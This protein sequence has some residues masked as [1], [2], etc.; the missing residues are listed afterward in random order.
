[1]LVAFAFEGTSAPDG[2]MDAIGRAVLASLEHNGGPAFSVPALAILAALGV[3]LVRWVRR[4][5]TAERAEQEKRDALHSVALSEVREGRNRRE[6]VRVPA[7]VPMTLQHAD[8][9]RSLFFEECETVD[10]S[11][12]GVSYR[13]LSPPVPGDC[14]EFTL[15]LGE[16]R[17]MSLRGIVVR[18]EAARSAEV[19][20]LV[21]V[22]LGPLRDKD[23]EHLVR[24]VAREERRGLAEARRGSPCAYCGRP[25][26]DASM[27]VHPTCAERARE[28]PLSLP[29]TGTAEEIAPRGDSLLRRS[30]SAP[31]R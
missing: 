4:D 31:P 18:V 11:G 10:L 9:R 28:A 20:S 30:S 15:N 8:V 21:G 6:W 26:E 17:P 22:R 27:Q 19:A 5:V 2:S 14:L 23:R 13:T 25:T 7:Q 12:G 29:P 24:W 1:M 16:P 3:L